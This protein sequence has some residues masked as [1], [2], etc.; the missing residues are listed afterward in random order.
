ML[1]ASPDYSSHKLLTPRNRQSDDRLFL[2]KEDLMN[3]QDLV[4]SIAETTGLDRATSA[5]VTEVV[6]RTIAEALSEGEEVHLV[7]F[8]TFSVGRRKSSTGRHPRTG[9]PIDIASVAQPKFRASKTL[10]KMVS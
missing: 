4:A 7:N 6:L 10:R 8:G 3:K 9:E 2:T 5:R 1:D